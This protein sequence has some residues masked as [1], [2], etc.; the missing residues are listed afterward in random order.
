MR[1]STCLA[2]LLVL[3]T[4]IFG[5]R[6]PPGPQQK[7]AEKSVAAPAPDTQT[8]HPTKTTAVDQ[9]IAANIGDPAKFR[10]VM[11]TLQQAVHGHD[12]TVVA[13]LVSYPI[14][15]NPK[16]PAAVTIRTPKDFAAHY[17]QIIT[18]H[19]AEV[20]ETQKYEGLFVN[21][22]GAML[23]DGEVWITGIC[24]DQTCSQTD[25]KIQ[26]IQNTSGKPKELGAPSSPQ[27]G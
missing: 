23:G 3:S 2:G 6:Q 13:A 19:I 27:S 17:D 9:A 18:P 15:I 21:Y 16:T 12:A 1:S 11:A 4:S 22:K 25:I 5:C 14:T 20:I 26:T 8:A 24:K 7:P 10:E